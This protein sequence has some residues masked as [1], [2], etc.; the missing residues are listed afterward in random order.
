MAV[1][2]DRHPATAVCRAGVDLAGDGFA[3][4]AEVARA[5]VAHEIVAVPV[6]AE[7]SAFAVGLLL[8]V[9]FCLHF[10]HLLSCK[11]EQARREPDLFGC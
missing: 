11:M 6:G 7:A 2:A 10:I 9:D 1:P 3:F 4:D 5:A 8:R